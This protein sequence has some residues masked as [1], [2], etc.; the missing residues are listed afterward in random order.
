M[1]KRRE[2]CD[3]YFTLRVITPSEYYYIENTRRE[4]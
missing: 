1:K 2:I 4:G 3:I